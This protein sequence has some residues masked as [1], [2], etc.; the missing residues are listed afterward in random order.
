MGSPNGAPFAGLM[1]AK[2][3]PRVIKAIA[4]NAISPAWARIA[5]R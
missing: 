4:A 3:P 1:Y 5:G 2:G